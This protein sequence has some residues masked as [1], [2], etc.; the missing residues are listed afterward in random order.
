[1]TRP[2]VTVVGPKA[3]GVQTPAP[4]VRLA[5]I[6]VELS[7]VTRLPLASVTSMR[8]RL[9]EMPSDAMVDGLNEITVLV[10]LPTALIV[11]DALQPVSEPELREIW[12]APLVPAT[13]VYVTELTPAD[14]PTTCCVVGVRRPGV[15]LLNV[16]FVPLAF[17]TVLPFASLSVPLTVDVSTPLPVTLD[18][19]AVQAMV[20]AGPNTVTGAEAERPSELVATTLH[21]WVAEFVAVAAKRPA[22]VIAPQPP[23]TDQLMVAPADAP[24]AVNCCVP[25]TGSEAEAG[26]IVRPPV[27]APGVVLIWK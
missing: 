14:V 18:G 15:L 13:V 25:P 9:C 16:M 7:V 19:F 21:G 12:P 17:V 6:W 24:L 27:V 8:R 26:V 10:A 11:I 20:D 23:V 4:L 22:L 2:D 3:V 1:M 5:V